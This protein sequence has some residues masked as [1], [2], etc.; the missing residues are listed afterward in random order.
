MRFFSE[1]IET[2]GRGELDALINERVRY[3]VTYA[4]ENSPFY[5]KWLRAHDID[6]R[7]IR[8]HEDLR[9]LRYIWQR[10]QTKAA[11]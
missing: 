3:T 5:R 10:R 9:E 1:E 4:A 7:T 6:P 8:E 2:M 11:T